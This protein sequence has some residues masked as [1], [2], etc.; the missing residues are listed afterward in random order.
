MQHLGCT[1]S[2]PGQHNQ[3]VLVFVCVHSI[4]LARINKLV[5]T[6]QHN[7]FRLLV[8]PLLAYLAALTHQAP[9]AASCP[10][11]HTHCVCV[12]ALAR[13]FG[14]PA[15]SLRCICHSPAASPQHITR[16]PAH[17]HLQLR[18]AWHL[19][20]PT[21]TSLRLASPRS[22]LPSP[23]CWCAPP[24]PSKPSTASL[25]PTPPGPQATSG[26]A[27]TSE[28]LH[29]ETELAI[30]QVQ[31]DVK[32]SKEAVVHMLVKYATTVTLA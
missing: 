21:A 25:R 8:E 23:A 18:S 29:K 2:P 13:G 32:A 7:Q 22:T 17:L 6:A 10:H 4:S 24:Q 27:A 19:R 12:G 14:T 3:C 11:Q 28:R 30:K 15:C 20:P 16:P 5:C 31:S 1:A 9:D 26:A